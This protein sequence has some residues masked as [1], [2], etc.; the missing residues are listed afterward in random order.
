MIF[1]QRRRIFHCENEMA[2]RRNWQKST[3]GRQHR[4]RGCHA[5]ADQVPVCW[6]SDFNWSLSYTPVLLTV[7]IYCVLTS[8]KLD[9]HRSVRNVTTSQSRGVSVVGT[10][11][12]LLGAKA[13]AAWS[14]PLTF[15]LCWDRSAHSFLHI[16]TPIHFR[17]M[18][19]SLLV[20]F[21]F[22][23]DFV[24]NEDFPFL[25]ESGWLTHS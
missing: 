7:C 17:G 11:D 23:T 5:A 12:Y 6:F 9:L 24:S 21:W 1:F 15:L 3:A 13:T 25:D 4:R 16:N 14:W 19:T 22:G 2:V 18:K 20:F 8:T 10:D